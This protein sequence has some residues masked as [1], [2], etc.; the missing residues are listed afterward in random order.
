MIPPQPTTNKKTW[1]TIEGYHLE[2]ICKIIAETE[3]GLSG[4]EIGRLL[5]ECD[6]IDTDPSITKWKRLFNAFAAVQN[7]TH[8]SSYILKFISRAMQPSRYLGNS[9]LFHER[10]H[11]LNKSLSFLGLELTE[12]ATFRDVPVASTLLDAEQRASK[13]KY[14]LE[15]RKVHPE[16]TRFSNA[17]LLADNYFHAVFEGIKSVAQ[18]IRLN[19]GVVADGHQLVDTVFSTSTP[20]IHINALQN[21]TDRNEHVGLGNLIKGLFGLIRNPVAHIPKI[22]FVIDEEQALDILTSV[23]MIHKR[24]D[25]ARWG[26]M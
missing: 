10:L 12:K 17:E 18:R 7:R 8:N 21:D 1:P 13:F 14:L 26:L 4:T 11:S 16:V 25:K 3:K 24:L 19:T 9:E 2:S 5:A 20:L 22:L 6:I 15:L 23:S